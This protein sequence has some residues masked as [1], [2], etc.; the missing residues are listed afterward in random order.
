[1]QS[2]RG[3]E[4]K[5]F[6]MSTGLMHM[7]FV[8]ILLGALVAGIDAG[9]S[10]VDWPMMSGQVFPPDAFALSPVWSN[11]FENAG[12]VQFMHRVWGYLF[13][14]FA[15]VVWR[16]G[17]GSAHKITQFAFNTVMAAVALQVLL[18]IFTVLYA[19]PVHLAIVH[20]LA[21]IL[22]WSLILW[23]RFLSHFPVTR[24]I[25]EG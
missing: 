7:A 16:A 10:F 5:L 23:A 14:I 4:A 21:A 20:Q 3:K 8:Q 1:M 12:L 22:V 18:G 15:V 19:A 11:F 17:R 24:S 9:R 25:R 13:A 2:R 6:S